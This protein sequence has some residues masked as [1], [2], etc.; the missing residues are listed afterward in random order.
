MVGRVP[1]RAEDLPPHVRAQLGVLPTKKGTAAVA[2]GGSSSWRCATC[3][4]RFTR[5]APAER[6]AGPGHYRIEVEL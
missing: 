4:E 1:V 5:W 2:K 6:H 3:G